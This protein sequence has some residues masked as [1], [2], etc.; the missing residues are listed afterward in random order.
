MKFENK[1]IKI[2]TNT[3]E[4]TLHNY[5]YD[6]Y[7]ALFS[8]SQYESSHKLEN[9]NNSKSLYLCFIKFE[10]RLEDITNAT[11][12]D[13]DVYLEK[14]FVNI[15]GNSNSVSTSYTYSCK[16]NKIFSLKEKKYEDIMNYENKKITALGFGGNNIMA[17][18]DTS[19]YDIRILEGETF[20]ITR[21]DIM[22]TD[23]EC[24]GIEYP[25]HLAS[26]S[27]IYQTLESEAINVPVWA[28]LY[29]IGFGRTR[30]ILDEEYVIGKEIEVIKESETVFGFNLLKGSQQ[31]IY[32]QNTVYTTSKLYPLSKYIQKEVYPS[33][34]IYCGNGKIPLKSNYKYIIYKFRLY[35]YDTMQDKIVYLNKYYTLNY[36]EIK[37]KGLFEIKTKI[38]RSNYNEKNR[39]GKWSVSK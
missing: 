37:A 34:K 39:L 26:T 35:Y 25:L 19:N 5:I 28:K 2:K 22:T 17:C 16:K 12:N 4:V 32:P 36:P 33:L 3:K 27:N 30:G 11:I 1:Y 31:S 14:S 29:S 13:F 20:V 7:L 24:E 21:K 10:N 23:G 9:L 18:V 38:E 15:T 8:Q 6:R